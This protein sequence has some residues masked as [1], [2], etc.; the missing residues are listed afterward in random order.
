MDLISVISSVGLTILFLVV[1][2][3]VTIYV[4]DNLKWLME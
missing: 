4:G 3:I 1:L 2:A